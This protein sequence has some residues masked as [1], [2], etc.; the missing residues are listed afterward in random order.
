MLYFFR[1]FP[2]TSVAN[3]YFIWFV[4]NAAQ[5]FWITIWGKRAA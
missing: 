3:C 2:C 5:S 1:V 4:N